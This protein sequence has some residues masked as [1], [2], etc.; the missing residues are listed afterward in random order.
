MRREQLAAHPARKAGVLKRHGVGE[1]EN[2]LGVVNTL[3]FT[4]FL[5]A[6]IFNS[7]IN[8]P[9]NYVALH[10]IRR[11]LTSSH[12]VELTISLRG[13][14]SCCK[15]EP[16]AGVTENPFSTT[17]MSDQPSAGKLALCLSI[18]FEWLADKICSL[19]PRR[20]G[21]HPEHIGHG[22]AGL[23]LSSA[24]EGGKRRFA[25]AVVLD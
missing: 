2:R 17:A 4:S 14:E 20:R 3:D 25:M 13:S 15:E 23:A 18:Y 5:N 22:L 24:E 12:T 19:A 9:T 8:I 7:L 10:K 16:S 1:S 21:P 11:A 6:K